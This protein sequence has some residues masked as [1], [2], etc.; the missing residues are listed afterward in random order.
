ML[1]NQA[2]KPGKNHDTHLFR[3]AQIR[4][5]SKIAGK[6]KNY[7]FVKFTLSCDRK[8]KT[9][10]LPSKFNC[11]PSD[12]GP[13]DVKILCFLTTDSNLGRFPPEISVKNSKKFPRNRCW[14]EEKLGKTRKNSIL[15][16]KSLW[17]EFGWPKLRTSSIHV[18]QTTIVAW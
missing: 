11:G 17:L 5:H 10:C 1:R 18:Y 15:G 4:Y 7:T 2:G 16:Q 12:F 8:S 13:S 14:S 9:P 6:L 3:H